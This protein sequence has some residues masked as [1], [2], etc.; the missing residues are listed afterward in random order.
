VHDVDGAAVAQQVIG[1]LVDP[2]QVDH[3]QATR[4]VGR[5]VEA[6]E[7]DWL[8]SVVATHAHEVTLPTT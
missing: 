4:I 3:Q 7:I 6:I 8:P 2:R 1:A 5:G